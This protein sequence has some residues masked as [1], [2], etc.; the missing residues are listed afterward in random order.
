MIPGR[1]ARVVVTSHETNR[2][3]PG[4]V[5]QMNTA[6]SIDQRTLKT[7]DD[8]TVAVNGLIPQRYIIGV[9]AEGYARTAQAVDLLKSRS[10]TLHKVELS[11][12]GIVRGVVIDRKERPIPDVSV[13]CYERALRSADVFVNGFYHSI[14]TDADGKFTIRNLPLD[15]PLTFWANNAKF[16]GLQHED[17]TLTADQ[18]T[19]DV[20]LT[21]EVK[22]DGGSVAGVVQDENGNAVADAKVANYG[23]YFQSEQ[24]LATTDAEGRFRLDDVFTGSRDVEVAFSKTGF[25]PR[26]LA[27]RPGTIAS[28]ADLNVTLKPGH[29][30]RGVISDDRGNAIAG[31]NVEANSDSIALSNFHSNILSVRTDERGEFAL[32]SLPADTRFSVTHRK[33]SSKK[34]TASELDTKEPVRI[35]LEEYGVIQG[36]VLDA[37]TKQP[38]TDFRI[39]ASPTRFRLQGDV[40]GKFDFKLMVSGVEFH[41]EDGS[42]SIE[43]VDLKTPLELRIEADG[44]ERAAVPR[45][46]AVAA[47]VAKPITIRMTPAVVEDPYA[48]TVQLVDENQAPIPDVAL[49]LIATKIS[50]RSLPAN[51]FNWALIHARDNQLEKKPYVEQYF[52]GTTDTDGK[53]E[54]SKISPRMYLQLAYE[55]KGVPAGRS[56]DFDSATAGKSETVV[57]KVPR[58]AIVRGS[59]DRNIFPDAIAVTIWGNDFFNVEAKLMEGQSTFEFPDLP[60]GKYTIRVTGPY[61][62][63][64]AKGNSERQRRTLATKRI[65]LQSGE[66]KEIQLD[67]PK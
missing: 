37:K 22:P 33:Y 6:Q 31:A 25:S 41:A 53:F 5:V 26:I 10:E 50:P 19:L 29:V 61:E 51:D 4:A 44:Y 55:R 43:P 67:M 30:I 54:F 2:P 42:F 8:G 62:E 20:R 47:S 57:V 39:W 60:S 3:I 14:L 58:P 46:V 17:V 65:E 32:D 11:P 28:P 48:L 21:L 1:E 7:G 34:L 23:T 38:I 9:H 18:R 63:T 45:V 59:I 56:L 49:W 52:R 12:E 15:E 66:T 27:V 35:T 13:G 64:S 24:R 40:I 36:L 16:A